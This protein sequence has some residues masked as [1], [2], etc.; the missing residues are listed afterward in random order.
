MDFTSKIASLK[1]RVESLK[2]EVLTEEATCNSLILPFFSALGYD[3]FSLD[4]VMPQAS[5]PIGRKK[6]ARVDY[7]LKVNGEPVCIVEAKP[8]GSNLSAEND[9][10]LRHYYAA[11][12]ARFGLL[13]DGNQ[14]RFYTDLDRPNILDDTPFLEFKI[15]NLKEP[16][17]NELERFCKQSF[18]EDEIIDRAS[19]LKDLTALRVVVKDLFANPTEDFIRVLLN[20]GVYEGMKTSTIISRYEPLVKKALDDYI[21]E[22]VNTRINA[23]LDT[24]S[25]TPESGSPRPEENEKA[26][27]T[28]AKKIVTTKEE[29]ESFY[30]VK[31]ILRPHM[32]AKR[33]T[34]KDTQPYFAIQIDNKSTRWICRLFIRESNHHR[35]QIYTGDERNPTFDF[36]GLDNLYTFEDKIIDAT[37]R[38]LEEY[39]K[40]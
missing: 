9:S 23:A 40:P 26:P 1:E 21:R 7:V 10:Q 36:T 29:I 27:E 34:Y 25:P 37:K 30:I 18:S 28:E 39:P 17:C 8:L 31:A 14:Y 3:P 13:T 12:V 11:S 33:L 15:E 2:S 5:V 24:A 4:D 38:R 35:I 19:D 6:D 16:L 20:Q 32:D 22:L